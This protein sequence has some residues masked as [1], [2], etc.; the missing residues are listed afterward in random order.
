MLS[1]E[2][3]IHRCELKTSLTEIFISATERFSTPSVDPTG[4]HWVLE[5]AGIPG[6]QE[7]SM[8]PFWNFWHHSTSPRVHVQVCKYVMISFFS[9][10]GLWKTTFSFIQAEFTEKQMTWLERVIQ[11]RKGRNVTSSFQADCRSSTSSSQL[12]RSDV[13]GTREG[14]S[15]TP[16]VK[17]EMIKFDK[18]ERGL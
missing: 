1:H 4:T 14:L 6:I 12:W 3:Y 8:D 11:Y 13:S 7:D 10:A 5:S 15:L 9:I 2:V 17:F 18:R 16:F